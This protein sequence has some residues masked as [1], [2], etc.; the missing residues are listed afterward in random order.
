[1]RHWRI[2]IGTVGMR[3]P[4]CVWCGSPNPRP[5]AGWEWRD[6]I[7]WVEHYDRA[8]KHVRAAIAEYQ[9]QVRA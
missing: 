4:V 9:K 2:A 5:L 6:L 3:T 8:G 1:M 7:D